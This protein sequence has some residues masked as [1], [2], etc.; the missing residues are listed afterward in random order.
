MIKAI[1]TSSIFFFLATIHPLSLSSLP[2][3]FLQANLPVANSIDNCTT[4]TMAPLHIVVIGS[5]PTGLAAAWVFGKQGYQ[6]TVLEREASVPQVGGAIAFAPNGVRV[7]ARH[8]LLADFIQ[9]GKG[10]PIEAWPARDHTGKLLTEIPLPS[11]KFDPAAAKEAMAAGK[12]PVVP[13]MGVKRGDFATFMH[14]Q[15][16]SKLASN[17]TFLYGAT[18]T[19][20]E[21]A[22]G[23]VKYKQDGGAE[24]SVQGTFVLGADG[25]NSV[26]KSCFNTQGEKDQDASTKKKT[27]NCSDALIIPGSVVRDDPDLKELAKPG[28]AALWVGPNAHMV[29]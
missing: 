4:T 23:I 17:V 6:I 21:S 25:I 9:Q 7:L 3:P 24:K 29:L 28:H 27:G 12:P 8:E 1:T 19:D 13:Q 14:E 16:T 2:D 22:T 5:G 18:V 11:E 26:A 20:I 10:G 15:I